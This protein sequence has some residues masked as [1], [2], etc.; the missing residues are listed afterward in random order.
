MIDKRK[1]PKRKKPASEWKDFTDCLSIPQR[2]LGLR[3]LDNGN[4][5]N[6]M[7]GHHE[8]HHFPASISVKEI[9]QY[10]DTYLAKRKAK[11]K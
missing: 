1:M 3:L 11:E 9:K 2:A 6:L 4:R 5:Y 7:D 10:A 8:V